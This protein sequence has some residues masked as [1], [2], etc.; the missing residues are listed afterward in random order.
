MLYADYAIADGALVS[1]S[2]DTT[3][4]DH[5][6]NTSL[7]GYR[8]HLQNLTTEASDWRTISRVINNISL[9]GELEVRQQE[10]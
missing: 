6:P 10:R 1:P 8:S 3:F 4:L 5:E 2:S 9:P 7:S